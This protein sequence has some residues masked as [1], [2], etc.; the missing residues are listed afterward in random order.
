MEALV[1]KKKNVLVLLNTSV[2]SSVLVWV[3]K[4]GNKIYTE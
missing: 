2:A 4:T 3:K 1:N